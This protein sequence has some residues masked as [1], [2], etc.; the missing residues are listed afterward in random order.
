VKKIPLAP[1]ELERIYRETAAAVA[2]LVRP[3]PEPPA[4]VA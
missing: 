3:K 2:P 4:K 1:E